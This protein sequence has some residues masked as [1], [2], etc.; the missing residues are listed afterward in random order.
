MKAS[1]TDVKT[2]FG[3]Y[4]N[5]AEKGETVIIERS[6]KQAVAI[7]DFQEYQYLR[8]LDEMLLAEKIK[9]AEQRGYL[10]DDESEQFFKTIIGRLADGSATQT[11]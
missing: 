11:E 7:I 5:L 4:L 8:Q 9:Q 6:G 2:H 1:A 3:H 10:S